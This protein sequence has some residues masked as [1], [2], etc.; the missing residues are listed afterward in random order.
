MALKAQ[1]AESLRKALHQL[2][3]LG[4]QQKMSTLSNRQARLDRF[5]P[6]T[7]IERAKSQCSSLSTR[8]NELINKTLIENRHRLKLAANK[9]HLVS[10]LATLERGYSV[11]LNEQGK[12]IDS[13]DQVNTGETIEARVKDGSLTLQVLSSQK[14]S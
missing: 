1:R 12:A 5:H 14:R 6:Q 9:L 7:Q 3:L 8:K 4:I 2:A 11:L 13:C 10:P